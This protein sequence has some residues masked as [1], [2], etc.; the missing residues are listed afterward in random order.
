[1]DLQHQRQSLLHPDYTLKRER[2]G[3]HIAHVARQRLFDAWDRG[4]APSVTK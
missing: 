2:G 4:E 3:G 1:M